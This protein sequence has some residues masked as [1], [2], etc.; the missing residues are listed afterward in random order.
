MQDVSSE[1][2]LPVARR[3]NRTIGYQAKPPPI[4]EIRWTY[5]DH[6]KTTLG[7]T[8]R[9]GPRVYHRT[10]LI[11]DRYPR[12]ASLGMDERT[13]D[14]PLMFVRDQRQIRVILCVTNPE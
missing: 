10:A 1:S 8:T 13:Y 6:G 7:E 12:N 14:I 5:I 2:G 11:W 9:L 4:F 3:E